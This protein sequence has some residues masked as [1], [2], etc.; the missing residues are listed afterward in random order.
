MNILS[1]KIMEADGTL[2]VPSK[3]NCLLLHSKSW[4]F[5]LL[6]TVS[7]MEMEGDFEATLVQL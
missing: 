2:T 6:G 4:Q 3:K 7:T 5:I 1:G